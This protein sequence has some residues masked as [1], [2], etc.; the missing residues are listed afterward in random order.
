MDLLI[1]LNW[2]IF[3]F[4]KICQIGQLPLVVNVVYTYQFNQHF[5]LFEVP[6]HPCGIY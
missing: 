4:H 1:Q 2:D 6:S 3:L 5:D